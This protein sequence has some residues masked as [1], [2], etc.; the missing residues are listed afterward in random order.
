MEIN[1]FLSSLLFDDSGSEG[2]AAGFMGKQ[3]DKDSGERLWLSLTQDFGAKLVCFSNTCQPCFS[4]CPANMELSSTFVA[5]DRSRIL[6][7]FKC[8]KLKLLH[9]KNLCRAV[10]LLHSWQH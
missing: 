2:A 7:N 9:I 3:D 4:W 8:M 6:I 5:P 10:V 1:F